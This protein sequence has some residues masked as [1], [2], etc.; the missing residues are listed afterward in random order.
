MPIVPIIKKDKEKAPQIDESAWIS[1]DA[2]IIGNVS[3]GPETVVYQ[4]SIIRGDCA[5]VKIGAK[6]VI[7]DCVMI[8]TAGGYGTKIG[9]NNLLGFGCLVH[10]AAVGNNS[11]IGIKST[12]MTGVK[13]GNDCLVGATA[14]VKMNEKVPDGQKWI[15]MALKGENKAGAMWE[16]GRKSWRDNAAMLK[17]SKGT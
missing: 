15:G 17:Q 6:N 9:D 14:F 1:E 11:V 5:K 16:M 12:L 10:G 7:Q 3:I 8:N 2:W 13:V 4:G